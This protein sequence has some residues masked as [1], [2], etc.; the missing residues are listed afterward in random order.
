MYHISTNAK[1]RPL[2]AKTDAL[3][4]VCV[5]VIHLVIVWFAKSMY[6]Q[7]SIRF[8][9]FQMGLIFCAR[10]CSTLN[11]MNEACFNFLFQ[12][13]KMILET[14]G[15]RV[16]KEVI[17]LGINL[18]KDPVNAQ[19]ICQNNGIRFLMKHANKNDDPLLFKMISNLSYHKTVTVWLE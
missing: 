11:F 17:A 18:A 10:Q 1:H 2:F 9:S 12:L 3:A 16:A 5:T 14:T 8:Y 4:S 7:F 6:Q 19:L 13:I 15:N